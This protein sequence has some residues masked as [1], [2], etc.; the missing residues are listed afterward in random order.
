MLRRLNLKGMLALALLVYLLTLIWHLPASF[1][2]HRLSAQLPVPVELQGLAGTLWSGQVARITVDGIDQGGLR[3]H[4]RPSALVRGQVQLDLEWLPRN[5]R[6]QAQLKAGIGVVRLEQVN[7][8]LDAASM[9]MVNKAPF[10][11]GGTWLLDVPVLELRDF[12]FVSTAH[13]RLVWQ[14]AAA[15]LP[16]TL[17]LGHLKAELDSRDGWLTMALQDQGEGP[18]G[19]QG[20]ARWRPGQALQLNTRIQAR[21]V[22]DPSLAG[23]VA[24]LGRP[25]RQG[26]VRWRAQLQ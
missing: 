23:A 13:G 14:E 19:L 7:G 24:L 4:W 12:E 18:L 9:A 16:Q 10:L 5:S 20:D 15:G 11:L 17:A 1:V 2:W 26:W 25:D 21:E 8:R 3:W 6:V 22:A